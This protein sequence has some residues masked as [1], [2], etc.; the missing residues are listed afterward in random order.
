MIEL[1]HLLYSLP[2]GSLC[3]FK[4]V[5]VVNIEIILANIFYYINI[6]TGFLSVLNVFA[7]WGKC[8][9][10]GEMVWKLEIW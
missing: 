4:T 7:S 9:Y 1:L 2:Y 3:S 5:H 8:I 10:F 6:C